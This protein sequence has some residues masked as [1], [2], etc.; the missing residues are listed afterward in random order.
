MCGNNSQKCGIRGVQFRNCG[1]VECVETIVR[2]QKCGIRG[3]VKSGEV[4]EPTKYTY[5]VWEPTK[6]HALRPRLV[7]LGKVYC[8]SHRMFGYIHRY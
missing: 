1:G 6:H 4:W 2:T 3:A 7:A 8:P 5:K